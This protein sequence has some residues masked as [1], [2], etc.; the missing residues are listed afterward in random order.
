MSARPLGLESGYNGCVWPPLTEN[1][2]AALLPRWG[3][4]PAA[5]DPILWHSRRPFSA[6]AIVAL[7]DG[8]RLFLKRHGRA[9]RSA[10]TLTEEH[11]FARR[12]AGQGLPVSAPLPMQD[13]RTALATSDHTYEAFPLYMEEDAYRGLDSW[14]PYHSTAQAASS[15]T[16]LARLHQASESYRAPPRHNPPLISARH[17]LLHENLEEGLIPW[18]SAQEGLTEA[19][20]LTAL[21]RD[22]LP[23][24]APFHEAL[25]PLL[26]DDHPLWGHGDWHG[27]N[28]LWHREGQDITAGRAFDFGMCDLTSAA[29]D[30]AVA[31]ER[32][33]ISWLDPEGAPAVHEEQLLTFL[34][35]YDARRPRTFIEKQLTACWLPLCHV[36]FALSEVAYYSHILG[37]REAA[38]I[39]WQDY[40][41]GHA[42]WFHTGRGQALLTL[43]KGT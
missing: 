2:I 13:G 10:E 7:E 8:G 18:A 3:V 43:L 16:L 21:R 17:P 19:Y 32:S 37:S 31:I 41:I 34:H 15:G 33:F 23:L 5:R 27:A 4:R 12:L 28:L 25:H 22:V 20:P 26:P 14:R 39:S 11:L 35:A 42:R 36:T 38:D 1:D 40:L 9:L 6:S 29:F 24:L 30:L